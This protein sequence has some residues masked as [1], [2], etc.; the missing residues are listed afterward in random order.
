LTAGV[1]YGSAR[2]QQQQRGPGHR[3]SE[4]ETAHR[5]GSMGGKSPPIAGTT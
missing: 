2:D 5:R 3:G 4:F 1:A